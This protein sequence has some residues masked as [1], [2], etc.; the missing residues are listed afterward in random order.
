MSTATTPQASGLGRNFSRFWTGSLLSNLA[1]GIMLTALPMAAAVLTNDPILVSGLMVARF[2][3]WLLLGLFAG[4]FVDRLDRGRIMVVANLVRGG[5]IAALAGL[6]ATGNAS[7]W[8]LYA[9]MFAV[10]TCEVFYDLS[11]RAMLPSLV[12]ATGLEKA[13][14]RLVGG[15]TVT[16]DFAGA[17]LAGLL[18]VVAAALP[19]AV[20][21][22]AYVLGALVLLGLPLAVRRPPVAEGEAPGAGGAGSVLTEMRAGLRFVFRDGVLRPT[23]LFGVVVNMAFMAQA[24]I[25][26]LLVQEYLEVPQ[27]LY[28]VFLA[29]SAVGALVGSVLVARVTAALGRFRTELVSF[30][31]MGVC[32]LVFG[33]VPNAYVAAAAW[34]LLGASM[35]VSNVVMLGA[36]QLIVPATHLGRVMSVMQ[37]LGFGLAPVGALLGGLLGRVELSHVPVASGI[38][39]LVA[40]ALN[41]RALSRLTAKA[42]AAAAAAEAAAAAAAAA[43]GS[44]RP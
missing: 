15:K 30:G 27:A 35:T 44:E 21:A 16:E 12:P 19:L 43:D 28:G 22:G 4:V 18:F 10:M 20:N 7:I 6:I 37:V 36:A 29:S 9:V 1:D 13:N 40:L 33:L 2:L 32:C 11:G 3:P 31:L 34:M 14:G 5:A 25:L 42:D 8:V 17:P 38:V 39:I 24:G 26:V 41:V 23:V